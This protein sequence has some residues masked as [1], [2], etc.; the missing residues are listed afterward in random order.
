MQI[1]AC[2]IKHELKE[3]FENGDIKFVHNNDSLL[4]AR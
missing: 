4:I 3:Y 1:F 2:K